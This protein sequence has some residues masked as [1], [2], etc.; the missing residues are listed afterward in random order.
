MDVCS[1][2]SSL[3]FQAADHAGHTYVLFLF[4]APSTPVLLPQLIPVIVK[5]LQLDIRELNRWCFSSNLGRFSEQGGS[6]ANR[7]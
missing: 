1:R 6:S 7:G 2:S 3:M 4:A 5:V